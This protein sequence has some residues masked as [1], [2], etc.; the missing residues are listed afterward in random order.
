MWVLP[1]PFGAYVW[2]CTC[3]GTANPV[4]MCGGAH[5]RGQLILWLCLCI[6]HVLTRYWPGLKRRMRR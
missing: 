6:A 4:L 3:E 2:W 5:V 1:H